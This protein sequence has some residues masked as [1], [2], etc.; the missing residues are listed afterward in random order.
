MYYLRGAASVRRSY[1]PARNCTSR[2]CFRVYPRAGARATDLLSLPPSRPFLLCPFF[3]QQQRTADAAA[4]TLS[5]FRYARIR[6]SGC[7]FIYISTGCPPPFFRSRS[8]VDATT[9]ELATNY[10]RFVT[11]FAS[12][13]VGFIDSI[14]AV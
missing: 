10:V 9:R 5:L 8:A 3:T 13:N 14:S 1:L 2:V 4:F 6:P 7:D 11:G 12:G